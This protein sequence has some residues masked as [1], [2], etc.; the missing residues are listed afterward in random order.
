MTTQ[1]TIQELKKALLDYNFY[2]VKNNTTGNHTYDQIA[3]SI[4]A[5]K[6]APFVKNEN[7]TTWESDIKAKF[8]DNVYVRYNISEKQAFCLARAFACI[9]Q[10]T[11]LN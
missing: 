1:T 2:V 8:C 10:E 7:I 3:N 11:I 9:N 6:I 4:W 5:E